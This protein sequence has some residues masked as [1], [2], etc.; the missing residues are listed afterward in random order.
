MPSILRLA[1]RLAAREGLMRRLG[2]L[3]G[4]FNPWLPEVRRDPYATYRRLR[5]TQPVARAP[6]LGAWIVS[7]HADAEQVLRERHFTTDRRELGLMKALR[8]GARDAPELVAFLDHDLLMVDGE[9]HVRLRRLV[10]KAFTPRR[11]ERLRP[12]VE[13]LV[14]ELLDA[15]ARRGRGRIEV[16][17]DLAAPLPAIVIGEM[18][19]VP[20]RDREQLQAWSNELVEL[21]DP[22]SGREG[23]EPPKRAMR[24]LAA[25]FRTLLAERREAPRDDLLSAMVAAEEA[26]E[27]LSE[28]EVLALASLILVAGHETTTNLVANAVL[29]LLRHPDERKRLQDDPALLPSAV[30]EFLRFESP[31]Q[32]TDRV[33]TRDCEV[34]G[35]RVR[36]GQLVAV[37]LGSANRDPERFHEP[38]RL[39]LAREDNRHL[40]FGHGSHFCL[41]AQLARLEA[42]VALGALLRRFPDFR[43]EPQP[44]GWKRSIVLRGPTA[45]PLETGEGR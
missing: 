11:V 24:A 17:R 18:L 25:Y 1:Q 6:L 35:V 27:R 39:D 13:A 40:A 41:G 26:G 7:R 15:A 36:A 3:M 37:L 43:G 31:I 8:R 20:D 19:G 23:L 12:R 32:L 42:Q 33:A 22:L 21:L 4:G 45:L 5:E 9:R 29:C 16:V 14:D 38:D 30:E 2:F 10:S 34:G 28:A 44:P